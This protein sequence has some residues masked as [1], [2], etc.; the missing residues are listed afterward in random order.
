MNKSVHLVVVVVVVVDMYVISRF[1]MC[2][3]CMNLK[4]S[5][6]VPSQLLACTSG[7]RVHV[8]CVCDFARR[9]RLFFLLLLLVP[10]LLL[11][12]LLPFD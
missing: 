10:L 11:Y 5:Y 4:F 3:Y 12:L 7:Q 2:L 9:R 1:F 6:A 8:L